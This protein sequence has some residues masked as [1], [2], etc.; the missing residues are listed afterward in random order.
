MKKSVFF[1][2]LFI[3]LFSSWRTSGEFSSYPGWR[4]SNPDLSS[5]SLVCDIPAGLNT[6]NITETSATWDWNAANGAMSYS[7][8]WRYPPNGIWYNLSGGPWMST[9]VNIIG[10]QPG[11]T[12]EWRV[13]SNCA[14]GEYSA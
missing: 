12:Y 7:I 14:N 6:I 8:Q 11:T 2:S 10:L 3:L 4:S 1:F 13:R 9:H 5:S